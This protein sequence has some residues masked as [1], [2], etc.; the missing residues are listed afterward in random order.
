MRF[1][2]HNYLDLKQ[3]G[4]VV[5]TVHQLTTFQEFDNH[6]TS[7]L[8]EFAPVDLIVFPE[9]TYDFP[10][11]HSKSTSTTSTEPYKN[12]EFVNHVK[13][14]SASLNISF[15]VCLPLL[16]DD[17]WYNTA[18]FVDSASSEVY[19]H[20]KFKIGEELTQRSVHSSGISQGSWLFSD[21]FGYFCMMV[22][23][24][25]DDAQFMKNSGE[26][27]PSYV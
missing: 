13:S 12:Q 5:A 10:A 16:H 21:N 2:V 8:S 18:L 19:Y 23:A 20:K 3:F 7:I 27:V 11:G 22:C 15:V 4:V 9:Y 14:L 6:V 24:D 1:S 26:F 25:I 17:T